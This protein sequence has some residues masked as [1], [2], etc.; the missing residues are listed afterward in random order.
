[1]KKVIFELTEEQSKSLKAAM[2]KAKETGK[3]QKLQPAPVTNL[4]IAKKY[5][6]LAG[7]D[8]SD[9]RYFLNDEWSVVWSGDGEKFYVDRDWFDPEVGYCSDQ[10]CFV[11]DF[12]QCLEFCL[13]Y[14]L[15][16]VDVAALEKIKAG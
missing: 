4:D 7:F 8:S 14:K 16:S 5:F 10:D 9:D 2:K 6:G 13:G 11:G 12:R 3:A 15:D 1:M